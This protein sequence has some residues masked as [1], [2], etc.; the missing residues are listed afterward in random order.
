MNRKLLAMDLDG[1][2]VRDD[3][4]VGRP[5]LEAI[6]RAREAEHII[7]FVSGRRDI[8]MLT[9]NKEEVGCADYLILN[10]GGKIIRLEDQVVLENELIDT[11]SCRK[12][13]EYCL[14][15]DLQLHIV[16]NLTWQVTKMT[17]DTMEYAQDVGVIPEIVQ[18]LS[19]ALWKDG[20]EG[21]M[22]TSDLEPIRQYI[23]RNLPAM[24]CVDS[25]PGCIDI[26]PS[27]ATK[28]SGVKKLASLLEVGRE[29]IIAVGN[30]YND[31]D[32]I[33]YAGIGVA[34]AN[35]LPA[36]KEEADYVTDKDNNNDAVAEIIEKMLTG[37]LE[38][39]SSG[40]SCVYL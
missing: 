39:V 1:T 7:A 33:K 18:S 6:E 9:M 36:V 25:E 30:Y 21:F 32:M 31:I 14:E 10:N 29:D 17:E 20:V 19:T 4:R 12:L 38:N 8:D 26:M 35:S 15:R 27:G 34:V 37:E 28:R 11:E 13:I 5:S 23:E 24:Y 2:T 3:Y 22:A 16:D 40:R